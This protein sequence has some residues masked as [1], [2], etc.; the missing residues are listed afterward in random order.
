MD[1]QLAI[2]VIRMDA[3][4][5]A[6]VKRLNLACDQAGI[7]A[8]GYGRKKELADILKVSPEASRKYFH[9]TKPGKGNLDKLAK[10]LNVDVAWLSYGTQSTVVQET[11][12]HSQT[13]NGSVYVLFGLAMA[14]GAHCA[15]DNDEHSVVDFYALYSGKKYDA[16]V[17]TGEALGDEE[18]TFELPLDYEKMVCFGTI[19]KSKWSMTILKLDSDLIKKHGKV[20]GDTVKVTVKVS[21]SKVVTGPDSWLRL[22]DHIPWG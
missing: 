5:E 2:T 14:N 10:H 21:G 1:K 11:R 7:A 13:A 8:H 20:K 22:V 3:E 6:F 16:C 12:E 18:Y 17:R 9:G 4:Q 15:F 19:P